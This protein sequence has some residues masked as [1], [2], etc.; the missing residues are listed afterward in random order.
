LPMVKFFNR[1]PKKE[2]F[3]VLEI[4][5][6][7]I[8]CAIFKKEENT[9]QLSGVGRKKFFS[10]EEVF[11][12]TLGAID[13]LAAIVPDFPHKGILGVCGGSLETTTTIARYDRPKPK[14]S[15]SPKETEEALHKVVE[16]LE[17]PGKK[18]FFSTIANAKIDG[19]K[20]TNPI[21][22]KG[23]KIELSCFAA[24]KDVEEIALIDRLISEIDLTVEKIVPVGFAVASMLER[25]NLKNALIYRAGTVRSEFTVLI[26]G[27]VAE[28]SPVDLGTEEAELLPFAWQASLKS[29]EKPEAP[30]LVWLFGDSDEVALDPLK[31][32]L[33][34]FDWNSRLGFEVRPKV[35]IAEPIHNFSPADMG[36]YAL[37]QGEVGNEAA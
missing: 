30:A 27:H 10:Q 36:I 35:E 28:I 11:D 1:K 3:L 18:I 8:T 17:V 23:E 15:I 12:A 32:N 2:D 33:L 4:G 16:K 6:E 37:S 29:V 5:L 24:F 22:L 14:S 21:G 26:D 9:L 34:A 13:A 31:E 19:V 25:R 7:R 20:V